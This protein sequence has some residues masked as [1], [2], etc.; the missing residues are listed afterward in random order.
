MKLL[1]NQKRN[2]KIE[3]IV[4][5]RNEELRIKD[6]ID[7]YS[8]IFDIVIID[9]GST[10]RTI[11]YAIEKGCTVYLRDRSKEPIKQNGPTEYAVSQ[12]INELSTAKLIF[13]LDIDE[14]INL[15]NKKKILNSIDKDIDYI[16]QRIDWVYGVR[17]PY[18]ITKTPLSFRPGECIHNPNSLHGGLNILET[19]RDKVK[20]DVEHFNV[21]S[22]R[23]D[24]SK[25]NNYNLIELS[26][27][28]NDN[29]LLIRIMRRFMIPILTLPLRMYHLNNKNINKILIIQLRYLLELILAL[30]FYFEQKLPNS[31]DQAIKFKI[32]IENDR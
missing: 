25:I 3:L 20:I 6:F 27:I 23:G 14:Y 7:N 28:R 12:Y 31:S 26:E 17:C 5:V 2:K 4:P 15:S 1:I 9:D 24:L 10:D 13:K 22:I 8:D 29:F 18:V 19:G 16:S 11:G 21:W 30:I 32:Y